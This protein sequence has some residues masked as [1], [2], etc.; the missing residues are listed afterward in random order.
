MHNIP[1]LRPL[2][3]GDLFDAAFQLYRRHFWTLSA[4]AALAYVPT[5]LL[6]WLLWMTVFERSLA[7]MFSPFRLFGLYTGSFMSSALWS[8]TIGNLLQGALIN[9][10]AQSYLGQPITSIAAYRFGL[11][12]YVMLVPASI[13][14]LIIGGISQVI[15]SFFGLIFG[16]SGLSRLFLIGAAPP[17][18]S[19]IG[20]GALV[21]FCLVALLIAE[22]A[23]LALLAYFLLAPQAVILENLGPLAAIRRSRDLVRGSVRR[24]LVIV[25]AAGILGFL[26]STV[27]SMLG[28]MLLVWS[29]GANELLLGLLFSSALLVG[30][31]VLQPL[32]VAIYTMFYYDQ[33]VRKEGY[34]LELLAQG[35]TPS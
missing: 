29:T 21:L 6:S 26:L 31:I 14:S 33:R 28:S 32:L 18:Q 22:L 24:G 9:A 4:I 5:A 17:L 11:R 23:L 27:P 8:L 20:A 35:M 2:S 34:D 7:G 30:Q 12:R 15:P 25:I 3:I 13:L 16:F 1:Q 10:I 19:Y